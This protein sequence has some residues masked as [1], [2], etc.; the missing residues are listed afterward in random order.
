ML[1]KVDKLKLIRNN[2]KERKNYSNVIK[3]V[4]G[5]YPQYF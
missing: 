4:S 2:V 1:I 5:S 3:K